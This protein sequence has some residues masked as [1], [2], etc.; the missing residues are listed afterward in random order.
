MHLFLNNLLIFSLY[1][2]YEFTLL[3]HS[4]LDVFQ[5]VVVHEIRTDA[6]CHFTHFTAVLFRIFFNV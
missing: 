6:K 3:A 5:G 1:S 2:I 4:I